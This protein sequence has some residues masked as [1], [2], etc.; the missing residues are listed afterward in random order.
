MA[1]G[2]CKINDIG[3]TRRLEAA[4]WRRGE[5]DVARASGISIKA[6]K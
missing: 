5:Q 1:Y 2:A 6:L 4:R 3:E